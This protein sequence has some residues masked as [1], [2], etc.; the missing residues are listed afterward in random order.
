M[1]KLMAC[2]DKLVFA[3]CDASNGCNFYTIHMITQFCIFSGWLK[4]CAS[5]IK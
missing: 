1:T 3:D 2:I 4:K 5:D